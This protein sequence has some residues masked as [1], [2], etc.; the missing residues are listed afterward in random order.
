MGQVQ[1]PTKAILFCGLLYNRNVDFDVLCRDFEE[2]FGRIILKSDS[3]PF[4]ETDYYRNE[5]GEDLTRVWLA[6][7]RLIE[8][9]VIVDIKLHCNQIETAR[10]SSSGKRRVNID[11]GYLTLGK[12]VLATTKNNQQRLYLG[13]GIYGEVTLRYVHKGYKPWEWT[14]SDYRR[15]EALNFFIQLRTILKHLLRER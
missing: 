10:S 7:D 8:P 4:H 3:F 13:G 9:D 15:S 11:P 6:F 1:K 5:M 12:V 2:I 14:Y